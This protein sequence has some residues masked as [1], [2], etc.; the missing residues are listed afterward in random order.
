MKVM[1]EQSLQYFVVEKNV[2][3]TQFW[4]LPEYVKNTIESLEVDESF[5]YPLEHHMA[6]KRFR[7]RYQKK[8]DKT[9][10]IRK[11]ST[12]SYRVWR[13]S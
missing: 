8:S 11:I 10:K 9:F 5:A 3:I 6:I 2:P 7:E 4:S 12:D 13:M 1:D